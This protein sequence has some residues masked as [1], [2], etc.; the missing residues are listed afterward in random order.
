M[1]RGLGFCWVWLGLMHA[2]LGTL[3]QVATNITSDDANSVD[4]SISNKYIACGSYHSGTH[5]VEVFNVSTALSLAL[6]NSVELGGVRSAHAVSWHPRDPF[7]AVGADA[8]AFG[9]D[10]FVYHLFS[11]SALFRATNR[12]ET[13]SDVTAVEWLPGTNQYLLA[14]TGQ[15]D[16][17]L[18]VF[19]YAPATTNFSTV[20]V[21]DASGSRRV[22]T[23]G[24]RSN[25]QGNR[26]AVAFPEFASDNLQVLAFD[27]VSLSDAGKLSDFS[28]FPSAVDWSPAGDR[29][30]VGFRAL[31]SVSRSLA[32]YSYAANTLTLRTN[33]QI[34]TT[35]MV[36]AVDWNPSNHLIAVGYTV[37][38]GVSGRLL[39]YRYKPA[40]DSLQLMYSNHVVLP[41][42]SVRWSR[43]GYHLAVTDQ[44]NMLT[45]WSL[46]RAD[47]AISKTG[48]PGM[49]QG[50]SAL[51]YSLTVT[52][53]GPTNALSVNV[54]DQ[55]PTNVTYVSATPSQGSCSQFA[56]VVYCDLGTLSNGA[57]ATVSI[58]VT[59]KTPLLAN[60]TNV[61][62]VESMVSD[63]VVTNDV[64]AYVT[65]ADT[66]GDGVPNETDNCPLVANPGQENPDG[67]SFGSACDN[68]PSLASANQTDTDGDGVGNVCDNC[69]SNA[70]P[71]QIN[72]DGDLYGDA[73]DNC[74]TNNSAN[75]TDTDGDL[76]GDICDSCPGVT[77]EGV[78]HDNDGIDS[79]CDPDKDGDGLPNDWEESYE[80]PSLDPSNA[81]LDPDGDGYLTWEEYLFGTVP[82]SNASHFAYLTPT[83]ETLPALAFVTATGRLYDIQVTS[84]VLGAVWFDWKTNLPGQ[85]AGINLLDTNTVPVRHFRVRA[86]V[87]P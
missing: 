64:V 70:N 20:T 38:P 50:G 31:A 47:L 5:D 53:R 4:W 41:V 44:A 81:E 75:F 32:L 55:L 52:N 58:A 87:S 59:V 13:G 63:F 71:D 34:G 1:R 7:V 16:A 37:G 23:N 73:C 8:D 35:H 65:K 39:V 10:L 85:A 72:T 62:S 17:E 9:A 69:I 82:I 76:I 36:N 42:Q 79:A 67:D 26:F 61:A 40:A 14:G 45:V 33:I 25:V 83:N 19:R 12:L 46:Q 22:A 15:S 60:F 43:D 11:N 3:F 51:A 66:D 57:Q 74:P 21:Y 68:C 80:L 24:V 28:Q 29:L 54:V 56:G 27:G 86:R 2:A 49:V 48:T 78:D 84:N 18:Q 30:I 77:N 6:T